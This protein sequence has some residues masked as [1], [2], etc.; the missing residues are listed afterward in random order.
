MANARPDVEIHVRSA[1]LQGLLTLT[2]D[3]WPEICGFDARGI[4]ATLDRWVEV[5]NRRDRIDLCIA[6]LRSLPW[7]TSIVLGMET[8]PQLHRNLSLFQMPVLTQE[9]AHAVA[10]SIPYVPEEV[11]NPS[12][13]R[14]SNA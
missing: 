10:E 13:W 2:A 4:Y 11:L 7:V 12:L 6:Y 1:L 3:D 5:L 8:L 9:Q 14:P